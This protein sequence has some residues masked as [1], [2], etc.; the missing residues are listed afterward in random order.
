MPQ[1]KLVFT[2]IIQDSQDYGSTEEHMVSRV[3][4]DIVVG[5]EVHRGL[6]ADVRQPVGES[7]EEGP[8]TVS[9]PPAI[10]GRVDFHAFS[11]HVEDYYRDAVGSRGRGIHI[12]GGGNI[13]MRNNTFIIQ[14]VVDIEVHVSGGTP[15]W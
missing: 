10:Q 3:F 1:G 12:A 5:K 13:R 11:R 8:L 9:F 15:G 4:F 7:F 6:Y 14:K 2:K